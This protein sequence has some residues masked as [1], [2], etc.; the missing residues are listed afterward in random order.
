MTG[1]V[2]DLSYWGS[3]G[4]EFFP[5][6][7]WQPI[8]HVDE[9]G[10]VGFDL[11]GDADDDPN[12]ADGYCRIDNINDA[13]L[14]AYQ[15]QYG[16]DATKDD[17]FHYIYGLLHSPE[18]RS[19]FIAD[20]NKQLPHVPRVTNMDDFRSF[21]AAGK[22]LG[23]LHVHYEDAALYPLEV[24][25]DEPQGD[26]FDWYRVDKIRYM[27]KGGVD[28]TRIIYN[29]HITIS[30]IPEEAQDYLLGSR[31][32]LDWIL[33]RHQVKTDKASGII[34]DPNDWARKVG[35]PRYI[36]DLIQQ[37]T[38]VSVRTMEIV[39]SLPPLAVGD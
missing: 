9:S 31:S 8:E 26:P 2:P 27:G 7:T 12:I 3:S 36:L 17:I 5:R 28:K 25:G 11:A 22:E 16:Q 24:V 19:Q 10:Q 1:L 21:V 32:G 23:A 33:E 34:N 6:W 30:G 13:T 18:Y 4:G 15:A 39:K 38:T 37:V 35:N 20:L 29:E 14:A